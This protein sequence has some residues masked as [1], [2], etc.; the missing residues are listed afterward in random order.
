MIA[1][2][3]GVLEPMRLKYT[4][5]EFDQILRQLEEGFGEND[6]YLRRLGEIWRLSQEAL[7]Y[8]HLCRISS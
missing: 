2:E 1:Q 3:Y 7:I 4:I 6:K 8:K 5:R